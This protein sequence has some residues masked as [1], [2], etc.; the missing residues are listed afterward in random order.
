MSV[1]CRLPFQAL[2]Q[3]GIDVGKAR[4]RTAELKLASLQTSR[5]GSRAS[6]EPSSPLSDKAPTEDL[7]YPGV[8]FCRKGPTV[9][10]GRVSRSNSLPLLTNA[11]ERSAGSSKR[12]LWAK[13]SPWSRTVPRDLLSLVQT[14]DQ[15]HL[16]PRHFKPRSKRN[17]VMMMT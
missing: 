5:E 1:H 13:T 8:E 15:V 11:A 3:D 16:K 12:G 4:P 9:A 10:F 6:T 14:D 17:S 2:E 7:L